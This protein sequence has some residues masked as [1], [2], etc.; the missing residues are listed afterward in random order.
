MIKLKTQH[1]TIHY[2]AGELY[3]VDIIVKLFPQDVTEGIE[4]NDL[5]PK[6]K[7]KIQ[8][9]SEQFY[10]SLEHILKDK[11][12]FEISRHKYYNLLMIKESAYKKRPIPN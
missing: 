8:D 1:D 11:P 2:K 5:P 3:K 10:S 7:K 12:T 6:T 4:L 9:R